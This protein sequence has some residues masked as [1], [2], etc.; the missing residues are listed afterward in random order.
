MNA[1]WPLLAAVI[2]LLAVTVLAACAR[3][4]DGADEIQL[5][6]FA[7][8][9]VDKEGNVVGPVPVQRV[10]RSDAEWKERLTAE[11]YRILRKAGTER[12]F[13]GALLKQK[14][15]GIYTCAGCGLPLFASNTKFESGTGWPSFFTAIGPGNV[16]ERSDTTH[17]MTRT[18][19]L[20]TR[21]NG[22][23]GHVFED[24]PAPTGRRFCVNSESLAFTPADAVATLADPS[25]D[26]STTPLAKV[27]IAGGCF[28]CVEAVFEELDGVIEAI[29][30]YAGGRPETAN[31]GDVATGRT[32]HAEAVEIAYDPAKIAYEDLLKVHFATHDPTTKNRQG[33][34]V[35]E[36][37]R[38][39]IFYASVEEKAVAE[40]V[41]ADLTEQK[42]FAKPIVTTVEPLTKFHR[43]EAYH[44][45][46]VCENPLA[47]YVRAVALPKVAK[48][49]SQFK[50]RLKAESPLKRRDE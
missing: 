30:G 44:Q 2:L 8:H 5:G 32:K 6:S 48:V 21:C 17:G 22:H 42:I 34:D 19:I 33:A 16:S 37:Y 31:Y 15:D 45:N 35:G 18:E 28:W 47:P 7:G 11:Q 12:A 29:S 10:N 50:D 25:A 24:G 3:A 13:T 27:V 43:A 38:S 41:I 4:G 14:A 23:L 26:A 9:L 36:Q 40:A 49:R 39:A 1:S 20:C 46:Y